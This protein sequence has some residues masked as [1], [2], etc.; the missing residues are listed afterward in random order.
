MKKKQLR[1]L[2][3]SFAVMIAAF[4]T[5]MSLFSFIMSKKSEDSITDI[6]N[7]YMSQMNEEISTHFQTIISLRLSQVETIIKNNPPDSF[8]YGDEMIDKLAKE[9]RIRNF[10]SLALMSTEGEFEMIYG[11]SVRLEDTNSF[12][13]SLNNEEK[14]VAIA[15][16][17]LGESC[18]MLGVSTVYPMADEKK[19]T[20]LVAGISI[21]YIAKSLSLDE[22]NELTYSQII[23]NDGSFIIKSHD[24]QRSNYFT[25]VRDLFCEV[26]G[27][28]PDD[29][30]N[31]LTEAMKN[32]ENYS[33]VFLVE[34]ERRHLYISPLPNSEWYIITVMPYGKLEGTISELGNTR[35]RV[36]FVCMIIILIIFL[37]IFF[38]FFRMTRR[39][40][41][42]VEIARKEAERANLAKSEFLSNMSHDIRTPMNAIVGM[43]AI[44]AANIDNKPQLQNCLKKIALSNKHLL[45]LINDILDMSKIES[46]KMT[47]NMEPI[48][49]SEVMDDIVNIAQPQINIKHQKFDILVHD[50][51]SES[52][53]SDSVRLNQVIINLFSNAIKFT[54]E[55]GSILLELFQEE[56]ELG[57]NYVK[58]HLN[59]RD[60]GIGMSE[61]FKE[62][63]FDSFARE[64]RK[65]IRKTEG[66][67]LG[68]AITKHIIDAMKGSI[69]LDSTIG[70]GTEF[71]ISIDME[72]PLVTEEE[73]MILPEWTM[74]VV[75]DD[76]LL[77][78]S[79]V[80]S[81]EEIGIKSE[82]TLDGE[83]AVEMVN[84]RHEKHKDYNVILLD[85]QLPG[86][87]GIET[88]R[89][90]RKKVSSD[91][92]IILISAYDWSD[93]ENEAY[94][95]GINGFISK[96]LFKSKLYYGLREFTHTSSK[97]HEI[98]PEREKDHSGTK[99]L[100]AEDND[101]NKEIICTLL[102]QIGYEVDHA[103]NGQICLDMFN[104]SPQGY[105]SAIL[106]DI[107][108]PVMTGYEATVKIRSSDRSDS[109]IPIIAMTAD[110]FS[111]DIKHCLDSG[112]NAHIAKP[113]DIKEVT[114]TLEKYINHR[115]GYGVIK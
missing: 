81:L 92:S 72:K 89:E 96:P 105:Y 106:M 6:G 25:R 107:R 101:L 1:F 103:E 38:F 10:E 95:A 75:D 100:V 22:S 21:D 51:I 37:T 46:G 112:M 66:T 33:S 83:S 61:D 14:K 8:E 39:Q 28:T 43:T 4:I 9:G 42:E 91:V 53:I 32:N 69:D 78:R 17:S 31:E 57:D 41:E 35:I 88:A 59:V 24:E 49:L 18:V 11:D 30:V 26:D 48:S 114:K 84:K 71:H 98:Q 102:A 58:V 29:Y 74:L 15:K 7:I 60:T 97:K 50:I 34:N 104:N 77:C 56:S 79:A 44:A 36:L 16:N 47:L 93:F 40:L 110:A 76:E 52:V 63:I 5:V 70:K 27:K 64:D 67:G 65:R 45:G 113:V 68:M 20:A 86:I 12:L 54:P 80:S 3:S 2:I 73:E 23:R 115:G 62:R 13:K 109:D 108:M 55:N 111:S 90:I 82:W 19:N 94:E 87:D 85:W 99:I